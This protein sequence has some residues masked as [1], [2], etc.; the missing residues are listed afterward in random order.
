VK[1]SYKEKKE[2]EGMEE[3]IHKAEASINTLE[4]VVEEHNTKGDMAAL[5]TACNQLEVAHKELDRL[6]HR[7]QELEAKAKANPN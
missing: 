5:Q 2:L 3:A 1:L 7:W 4:K 6:Y